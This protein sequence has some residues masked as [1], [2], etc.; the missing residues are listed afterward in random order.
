VFFNNTTFVFIVCLYLCLCTHVSHFLRFVSNVVVFVFFFEEILQI[1]GI[2]FFFF[3][4]GMSPFENVLKDHWEVAAAA[5]V[6]VVVVVAFVDCPRCYI[7]GACPRWSTRQYRGPGRLATHLVSF[8]S[9]DCA[10]SADGGCH[11]LHRSS[12]SIFVV[13]EKE[14]PLLGSQQRR[15]E[16]GTDVGT[17]LHRD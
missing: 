6:G 2:I 12:C 8:C 11:P 3:S 16:T 7:L 9:G 13:R 5:V 4:I 15:A 10:G 14:P 17:S 1:S